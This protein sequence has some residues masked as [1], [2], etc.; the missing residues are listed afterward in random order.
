MK[1]EF[2]GKKDVAIVELSLLELRVMSSMLKKQNQFE[3]ML[4][5]ECERPGC[6]CEDVSDHI[7][8]VV[9]QADR[10]LEDLR[11]I[12]S[13]GIGR[14]NPCKRALHWGNSMEDSK[15]W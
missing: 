8:E 5:L 6:N 14:Y 3:I 10:Y 12:V 9:E 11:G 2:K 4:G 15:P 1:I 7:I 13:S